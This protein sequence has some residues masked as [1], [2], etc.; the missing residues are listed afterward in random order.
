MTY[1]RCENLSELVIGLKGLFRTLSIK[2]PETRPPG[3]AISMAK[4]IT[5]TI[6]TTSVVVLRS[7]CTSRSWCP[8]CASEFETVALTG[9]ETLTQTHFP[10]LQKWLESGTVH[11]FN[12]PEGVPLICPTSLQ[13]CVQKPKTGNP[14][15]PNF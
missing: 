8:L 5:I 13:A 7:T 1:G 10:A 9:A 12:T 11:H 4:R 6:E 2:L 15:K 3:K 14:A